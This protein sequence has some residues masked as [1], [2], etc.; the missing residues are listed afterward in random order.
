M[1][2]ES[3]QTTPIENVFV[4]Y[5]HGSWAEVKAKLRVIG[6]KLSKEVRKSL[7]M[8]ALRE[9]RADVLKMCMGFGGFPYEGYFEDEANRVDEEKDPETFQVL[10]RS[11]Y[12]R[13]YPKR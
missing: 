7:A 11:E 9:R 3:H 5:R 12:R 13:I 8:L 10:E 2:D 1:T 6:E 4:A